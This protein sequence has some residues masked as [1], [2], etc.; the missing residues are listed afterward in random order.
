MLVRFE[1]Y[2]ILHV[3]ARNFPKDKIE[4]MAEAF[5]D[6]KCYV[7]DCECANFYGDTLKYRM[8]E[9]Y[10]QIKEK[11]QEVIDYLS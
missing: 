8:L 6:G 9:G 10:D 5:P 1:N 7:E 2:Q 11:I 3:F 4:G